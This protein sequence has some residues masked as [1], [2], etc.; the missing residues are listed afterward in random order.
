MRLTIAS[1]FLTTFMLALPGCFWG[2]TDADVFFKVSASNYENY[3]G[4]L[5]PEERA[6]AWSSIFESRP[7]LCVGGTGTACTDGEW[8]RSDL[9]DLYMPYNTARV[10]GMV[11][12][13]DDLQ[14]T[15]HLDVAESYA[16]HVA[17]DFGDLD[18]LTD[19][20]KLYGRAGDGCGDDVEDRTGAGVCLRSELMDNSSAY[21]SL[22]EDLRLVM[23]INL[24][25]L[26]D[27][28]TTACQDRPQSFESA[29]WELPRT[30]RVNYNAGQPVENADGDMV[31]GD[32]EEE[33]PLQQCDIEVFAQ[34]QLG[35]ERF[36]AE[37]FGQED[38]D[39]DLTLDR[40]NSGDETMLGT[41]E[42][43]ALTMPGE[44]GYQYGRVEGRYRLR[45][46]ADRF[47]ARD[48]KVEI[49]GSFNSEIRVDSVEVN[50]PERETDLTTGDQPEA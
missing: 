28:R 11:T 33:P 37:Y 1:L 21:S 15:T 17:D 10:R 12:Q 44:D 43:T 13:K 19:E 30:L 5:F 36:N 48:G 20:D 31:Y 24:P 45:F 18:Y 4:L 25:G 42:I 50:E 29:D 16:V 7:S 14:V 23:L 40:T 32:P 46:T 22:K 38:E 41:V 6:E 49:E 26:D 35:F 39:G 34:L 27:V 47:A 2:E 9:L 8:Q 3:E